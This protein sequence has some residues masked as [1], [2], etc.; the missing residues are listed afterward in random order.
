MSNNEIDWTWS[1]M[2]VEGLVQLTYASGF[3][4]AYNRHLQIFAGGSGDAA[5]NPGQDLEWASSPSGVHQ[6]CL[7]DHNLYLREIYIGFVLGVFSWQLFLCPCLSTRFVTT[8][9]LRR[10]SLSALLNGWTRMVEGT[11]AAPPPPRQAPN[12]HWAH[13]SQIPFYPSPRFRPTYLKFSWSREPPEQGW[14][15]WKLYIRN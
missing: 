5:T 12:N 2:R 8:N 9:R 4:D 14:S 3:R 6:L 7:E 13:L 1:G 10:K 15:Y 11:D